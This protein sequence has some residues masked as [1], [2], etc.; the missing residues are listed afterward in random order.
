[1]SVARVLYLNFAQADS[2]MLVN[3][4]LRRDYVLAC[5]FMHCGIVDR[6]GALDLGFPYAPLDKIPAPATDS[7][8]FAGLCDTIGAEIVDEA[9][10]T[11]REIRVLWSGGI[12]STAALVAIIKAAE[13][14]G[15]GHNLRILLSLDSVHEYPAFF[16]QHIDGRYA[17]C[18]ARYPISAALDPAACNVTGEHGDQLFGSQ[19]LEPYVRRG[20]ADVSYRDILPLVVAER[21]RSI[22]AIWRVPRYLDPVIAAAPV[23]IRTLFDCMWWLNFVLKWQD[24]SLRLAALRGAEARAVSESLRH[25]FRDPRFQAWA[26]ARADTRC[27]PT[28]ARY[29]DSAKRYILDFTGDH[30]YYRTKVKEDSLR[31]VIVDGTAAIAPRIYM[32]EDF[33]AVAIV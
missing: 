27:P 6:T 22:D 7:V 2:G 8:T 23:P 9:S 16:L 33:R 26:L 10:R 15:S 29:K 4:E 3:A 11:G 25:F 24:V 28:W 1:M 32:T 30:S 17:T 5:R 14:C 12:D 18:S 31:N 19:L 13:T 20:L 21:V